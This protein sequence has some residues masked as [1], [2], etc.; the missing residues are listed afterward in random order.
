MKASRTSIE[1]EPLLRRVAE[2]VAAGTAES[3]A[4]LVGEVRQLLD[5]NAGFADEVLR[6]Y[7]QLSLIFDI[8]QQITQVADT[9]VIE[10]LV[11]R[12]LAQLVGAGDIC[13]MSREGECRVYTSVQ[14]ANERAPEDAVAYYESQ[15]GE[16]V[17]LVRRKRQIE[18]CEVGGRQVIAGPLL[19]LDD[20]VDVV[21][22]ARR[23]TGQA[24][25]AGDA[26]VVE[27]VLAFGGQIIS[28]SELNE[29]LRRMS[30]E[31]TRALVAAVDKKDHYT[32]GHSERV[33][34]L[35]R[36]IAERYGLRPT[37]V[38]I[39]EWAGLL[40]DIG[41]IG[42]HEEILR[43]PGKLTAEEFEAIKQHPRMG[44]E[45]L[46]PIAS[47]ELV[48][49][50]VLYHHEHPDGT[51][52]PRGP[53]TRRDSAG[54]PNPPRGGHLRRL[55]VDAFVSPGL[56]RRQGHADHPRRVRREDRHRGRRQVL[57]RL[58]RLL[59]TRP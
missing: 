25:T 10:R 59:Q 40:H 16:V 26:L 56:H 28:N 38:Q 35:T 20:K 52:Y 5:E 47:F 57:L 31:V 4:R 37:E 7:E 49:D 6:S 21:I 17:E 36:L 2:E 58:R 27:S 34:F 1:N 23:A 41:K 9:R 33:G 42:I 29:R 13:V 15:L 3:A 43:K 8:T 39:M 30:L 46:K 18:A 32:S 50:G 55:D 22:A 19:R 54:G 14:C 11:L 51:G 45:I 44:Y 53:A 48:L 12:R 24:L